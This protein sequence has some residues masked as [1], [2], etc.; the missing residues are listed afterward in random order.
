[1]GAVL[2][3]SSYEVKLLLNAH[4]LAALIYDH[5]E[6]TMKRTEMSYAVRLGQQYTIYILT[7]LVLALSP[8]HA[9]QPTSGVSFAQV[10]FTDAQYSHY[11]QVSLDYTMLYGEGYINVER[12][13]D[14]Q[15]T[16]WVVKNLPVVSGAVLSEFSTMFD[17]GASGY[18]Q[19]FSAYVDFSAT[20]LEDDSSLR[21]QAPV[22]YQ[23]GKAE[24]PVTMPPP[25]KTY[26]FVLQKLASDDKEDPDCKGRGATLIT[27]NKD[28]F[29]E[30]PFQT[31]HG[32]IL[33]CL[34]NL[35]GAPWKYLRFSVREEQKKLT[36]NDEPPLFEDKGALDKHQYQFYGVN[37]GDQKGVPYLKTVVVLIGSFDPLK[38]AGEYHIKVQPAK[39]PPVG[40]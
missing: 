35:S 32:S 24:Y 40:K 19:F 21:N 4:E 15:P 17:L 12:Y 39:E 14:G 6:V 18:H 9:I 2:T 34:Q 27:W 13:Q 28:D 22:I 37:G 33:V 5:K 20:P 26:N 38:E 3:R 31:K 29:S 11:G 16:G 25:A 7:L 10:S 23:L 30:K 8:A 1:M 36:G